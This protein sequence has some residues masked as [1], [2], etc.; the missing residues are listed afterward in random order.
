MASVMKIKDIWLKPIP[1]ACYNSNMLNMWMICA[2]TWSLQVHLVKKK[3][4]IIILKIVNG[5]TLK[6]LW[7]FS[8]EKKN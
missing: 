3:A 8:K 4:I 2:Y 7:F 6:V 5:S 1:S